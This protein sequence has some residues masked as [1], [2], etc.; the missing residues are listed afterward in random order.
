[1]SEF[2]LDN[3]QNFYLY[4]DIYKNNQ[5][6]KVQTLDYIAWRIGMYTMLGTQQSLSTKRTTIF[7][8]EPLCKIYNNQDTKTSLKDR[9]MAGVQKHNEIVRMRKSI[10][11]EN[12]N[13]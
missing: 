5:E 13:G 10:Q 6:Q 4:G 11:G 1:M 7:P 2:W 12:N 9:I 8:K 3:P